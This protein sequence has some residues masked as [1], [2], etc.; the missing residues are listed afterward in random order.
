MAR[1]EVKALT[2]TRN[3]ITQKYKNIKKDKDAGNNNYFYLM[4]ILRGEA[5]TASSLL[6]PPPSQEDLWG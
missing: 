2:Y 4:I 6:G 1:H 5:G 3:K